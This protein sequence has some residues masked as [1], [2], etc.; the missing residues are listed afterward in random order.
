MEN[1]CKTSMQLGK[2]WQLFP[3]IWK[4][5]RAALHIL[6]KNPCKTANI[7]LKYIKLFTSLLHNRTIRQPRYLPIRRRTDK[8]I[9]TWA[10]L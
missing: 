8:T 4:N 10:G 9:W 6:K 1:S 7:F 3:V 2:S 5:V